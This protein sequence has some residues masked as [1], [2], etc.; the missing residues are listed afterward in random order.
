MSLKDRLIGEGLTFDDV[1]LIPGYSEVLPRDVDVTSRFTRNLRLNIPVVSAGMDTVTGYSMATAM[2]REGGLGVIHANLEAQAQSA[3]ANQ[4]KRSELGIISDPFYLSPD[5]DV[6]AANSMMNRY[7]ISG[8]PI[9]D[10]QLHLLG[11]ITNRD[12]RFLD[13][14]KVRIGD[15]MTRENLITAPPGISLNEAR[16]LMQQNKVEKLPLVDGE[17]HLVGLVTIKDIEKARQYPNSVRDSEGRLLVAAGV[18]INAQ[19]I[20]RIERLLEVGVDCIVLDSAHGHSKGVI[21]LLKR[22]KE[23]FP[24][25]EVAAGNVATPEGTL[26]LIEAGADAV[27]VGIGPGSICTTRVVSGVGV[28]QI[29]AIA[30]CAEVAREYGVPVIADGGI[31]Y[32]GDIVKALAA[33]AET[34]MLGGL[35]AGTEE[36]PGETI[37]YQGRSYKSY[38]GMGSLGAM[39]AG[40][41]SR[42]HQA[43]AKKLVPEGIE[44]RV[45][46]KGLV[47]DTLFQL[48]GGLRA[49]MGY[50]GCSDLAELRS[51]TRFVRITDAGLRESHPHD[52]T[53]TKESPNYSV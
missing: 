52:V 47:A 3:E 42:Y 2:A 20:E 27:K 17:N 53:I 50:C 25:L 24:G 29:T 49:G 22:V 48:I 18:P 23:Y 31:K 34:V 39:A 16:R 36:S 43:E 5:D 33:G 10:D 8:V 37:I 21:D 1:L 19:S 15:V 32:S 41:S 13:H 45:P 51:K 35:L 28:P 40:S 11:I 6:E 9:V 26:A 30:T 14:Y 7:R 46:Y 44:G 38:R 12:I 4:V